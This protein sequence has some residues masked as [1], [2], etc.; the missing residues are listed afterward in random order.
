M[1]CFLY[2][3]GEEYTLFDIKLPRKMKEKWKLSSQI[4]MYLE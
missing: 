1:N 3:Y 2:V 4:D